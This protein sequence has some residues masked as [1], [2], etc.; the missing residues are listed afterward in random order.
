LGRRLILLL[1]QFRIVFFAPTFGLTTSV[2]FHHIEDVQREFGAIRMWGPMS[3]VLSA[4]WFSYIWLGGGGEARSIGDTFLFSAGAS[5]LLALFGYFAI[6][7]LPGT[8]AVAAPRVL[9]FESARILLRPSLFWLCLISLPNAAMHQY[10]YY[11]M[12]PY[13][14]QLGFQEH[15][16]LPLMSLGQMSEIVITFSLPFLV[17]FLGV[18]RALVIGASAQVLRSLAYAAGLPGLALCAIPLHGV[19]FALYFIVAY[20]YLD[21]H[22]T[23]QQRAGVQQLFDIF[24]LGLGNLVGPLIAGQVAS[25]FLTPAGAIDY[26]PYWLVSAI[27]SVAVTA[28]V[29][30]KFKEERLP[31]S[32]SQPSAH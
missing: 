25:V 17:V 3:W 21:T 22:C 13:L 31:A 18:K 9:S 14:S 8:K 10:Y 20:M 4:F 2:C 29:L 24:V 28:I 7:P 27:I 15:H 1:G 5:W 26:R 23:R 19:S 11:G 16:L 32:S 6:H 30:F 12:A